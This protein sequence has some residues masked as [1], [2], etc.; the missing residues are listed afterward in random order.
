MVSQSFYFVQLHP[1]PDVN[2]VFNFFCVVMLIKPVIVG[3]ATKNPDT[4]S[5]S[6]AFF[7]NFTIF[8]IC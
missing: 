7:E 5:S 1:G 4:G 8:S 6:L 2:S 3:C